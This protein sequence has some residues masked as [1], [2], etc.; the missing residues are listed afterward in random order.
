MTIQL[1][2]AIDELNNY[3]NKYEKCQKE[4]KEYKDIVSKY[5]NENQL[6]LMNGGKVKKWDDSTIQKSI[7]L[8]H[9]GGNKLINFLRNHVIPVVS[10][11]SLCEIAN[12]V[13]FH[14]GI[15]HFNLKILQLLTEDFSGSQLRADIKLDEK[16]IVQGRDLDQSS[17]QYIGQVTLPVSNDL[18]SNAIVLL[19]TM[20]EIRIKIVIGLHFT[21]SSTDGILLKDFIFDTIT[22]VETST[23]IK[24]EALCCDMGPTNNSLV[25]A[26]GIEVKKFGR[27]F[28]VQHPVE[29]NRKLRIVFDPVHN[30][31]NLTN[32]LRKHNVKIDKKFVDLFNLK[33]P[34]ACFADIENL[35]KKQCHMTYKP[36]PKLTKEVIAPNHFEVMHES[37]A[38]NL[39]DDSTIYALD[40]IFTPGLA[41]DVFSSHDNDESTVKINTTSWFLKFLNRLSNLMIK[42]TWTKDNF[43]EYSDWLLNVAV[44]ILETIQFGKSHLKSTNGMILA[45]YS[46]IDLIK[47]FLD[48]GM[49]EFKIEWMSNNSI[50][51]LFSQVVHFSQKPSASQ[52]IQAIKS[53][54]ISKFM[55]EP[56]AVKNY[57]WSVD[58]VAYCSNFLKIIRE[59]KIVNKNNEQNIDNIDIDFY[60]PDQ[61]SWTDLFKTKL[62]FNSFILRITNLMENFS[63]TIDCDNCKA[64]FFTYAYNTADGQVLKLMHT[65]SCWELS[66]EVISFFMS[67]E[68]IFCR[69]KAILNTS[70]ASFKSIFINIIFTEV[71]IDFEHCESV[72]K[73]LINFFLNFRLKLELQCRLLHKRNKFAS[74]CN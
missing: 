66:D 20:C 8:K 62:E 9:L 67:L 6:I 58:N 22:A 33:T 18:A 31:K 10:A 21:G 28:Y 61:I 39:L 15:L 50:E 30:I 42:A 32:G 11:R 7:V 26:M 60:I 40:F 29:N 64:K 72:I 43:Q 47:D 63:K 41:N 24:I 44:P 51:N 73:K 52:F 54:S 53:I 5:V 48:E 37:T 16:S 2:D 3:K 36:S 45:I 17:S 55:Q 59:S 38:Y 4:F 46:A 69:L 25:K 68:Y 56:L 70:H 27:D 65:K 14:P 57:K 12:G 23:K 71:S 1:H 34:F 35:Y 49:K 74:K 13:S 19:L